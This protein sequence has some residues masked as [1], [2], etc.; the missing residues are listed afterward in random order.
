M[1]MYR[2]IFFLSKNPWLIVLSMFTSIVSFILGIIFYYKSK[3][4]NCGTCPLVDYFLLYQKALFSY[5]D[6]YNSLPDNDKSND[7]DKNSA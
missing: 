7:N 1:F 4:R 6:K 3:R 5:L 2:F